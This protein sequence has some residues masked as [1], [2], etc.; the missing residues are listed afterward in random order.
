MDNSDLSCV[1]VGRKTGDEVFCGGIGLDGLSL[2][3]FWRWYS[4]DLVSNAT[5][6]ILAEYLVAVALGCPLHFS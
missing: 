2:K 5:R 6:G 4:S 1:D 3:E